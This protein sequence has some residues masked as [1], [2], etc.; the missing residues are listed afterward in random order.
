[1]ACFSR[2]VFFWFLSPFTQFTRYQT[3]V[4]SQNKSTS[5][6]YSTDHLKCCSHAP[7]TNCGSKCV[8]T[9]GFVRVH[10]V[11][12]GWIRSH[13]WTGVKSQYSRHCH[14][15]SNVT[16][17]ATAPQEQL[18]VYIPVCNLLLSLWGP[19]WVLSV[20]DLWLFVFVCVFVCT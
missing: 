1:M 10:I 19:M 20:K 15:H 7:V 6:F 4:F 3:S 9:S 18:C 14:C 13:S 2:F 8:F 17:R 5:S 16:P 12:L 11:I